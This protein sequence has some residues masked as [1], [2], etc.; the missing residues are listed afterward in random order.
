MT[1]S[2]RSR[3]PGSRSSSSAYD[4]DSGKLRGHR[5][6]YGGRMPVRNVLS[7][8][9]AHQPFSARLQRDHMLARGQHETPNRNFPGGRYRLSNGDERIGSDLTLRGDEVRPD[10]VE[11]VDLL[12]RDELVDVDGPG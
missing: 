4:F 8:E 11:V 7:Q 3:G 1:A 2:E 9:R 5:S 6:I 12:T 10:V